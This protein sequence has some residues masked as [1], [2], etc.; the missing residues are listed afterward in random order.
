VID[1]LPLLEPRKKN[2]PDPRWDKA[3]Y[4]SGQAPVIRS[5]NVSLLHYAQAF[6]WFH[7]VADFRQAE[8]HLL[9]KKSP[10]KQT[11]LEHRQIIDG[12]ISEGKEIVRRIHAGG[13]LI[14]PANGFALQDI[15]SLIEELQN[16]QLQWNGG[17]T[18]TRKEEILKDI[19][20]AA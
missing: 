20:D 12:L 14:K 1:T 5:R 10:N 16:T 8:M 17:M 7:R 9:Y 15:Q 3:G 19:F 11:R 13:G 2:G 6:M 4:L 18:K